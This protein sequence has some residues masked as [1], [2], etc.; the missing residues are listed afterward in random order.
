[1]RSPP[2]QVT[3][4]D[5]RAHET[6]ATTTTDDEE[7]FKRPT[8]K[9]AAVNVIS[10]KPSAHLQQEQYRKSSEEDILVTPFLPANQKERL[11]IHKKIRKALGKL[12][13]IPILLSTTIPKDELVLE[14]TVQEAF[15]FLYVNCQ[16]NN[17][18]NVMKEK[19]KQ[20][21]IALL[22][23]QTQKHPQQTQTI[24]ITEKAMY[25]VTN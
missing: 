2:D 14:K 7:R 24:Y 8:P 3:T 13:S 19:A 12:Q 5:K 23:E 16:N 6:T 11:K 18:D 4:A 1:M 20:H 15:T 21:L 10:R 22:E 17:D 9:K 25:I